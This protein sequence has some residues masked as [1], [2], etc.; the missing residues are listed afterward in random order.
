MPK[1]MAEFR[2][3]IKG[4]EGKDITRKTTLFGK[5]KRLDAWAS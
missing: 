3:R 5:V 2:K 4:R 1:T